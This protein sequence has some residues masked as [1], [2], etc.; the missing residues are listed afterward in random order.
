MRFKLLVIGFPLWLLIYLYSKG[1]YSLS[2]AVLQLLHFLHVHP[3]STC[4]TAGYPPCLY[5]LSLCFIQRSLVFFFCSTSAPCPPCPSL[6][7]LCSIWISYLSESVLPICAPP[8]YNHVLFV[9][10]LFVLHPYSM[11]LF[12]L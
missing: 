4:V 3:C 9:S 5:L 12:F 8:R 11:S 7:Y 1:I 6:F 2:V 10:A